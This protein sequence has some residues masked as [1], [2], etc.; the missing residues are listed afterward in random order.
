MSFSTD[1]K[2]ELNL[3]QIK[4][5]CCKKAYILGVLMSSRIVNGEIRLK[6]SDNETAMRFVSLLETAYKIT[7]NVS[8][9]T[10]GCYHAYEISFRSGSLHDFVLHCDTD[11]QRN[12][13][14]TSLK[15]NNCTSTFLRA[16]F[17]A[18]GT[19]SDPKKSY[20]LEL[21][22]PNSMRAQMV[23]DAI[24]EY[25]LTPPC[26]TERRDAVGLFYRN[27]SSIEDVLTACGANSALFTFFDVAVE[28]NLRNTENR[29]TNCVAKNISKS[30]NAVVTQVAAIEA[31]IANGMFDELSEELKRT[32][33]LRLDNP[34]VSLSELVLLHKP[35]ISK[36]G[37]NHRLSRLIDEAKRKGLI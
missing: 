9:C 13:L 34:D 24:T 27:E 2:K 33:M 6:L 17:C 10:R 31:L 4:G 3:I 8:E 11:V 23:C 26:L 19:V 14:K 28:K 29:A 21:R 7:P 16:V 36:S 15:C 1:V 25:G 32:A 12:T 30:V 5:N 18:C 22:F 20:T 37:L 35:A